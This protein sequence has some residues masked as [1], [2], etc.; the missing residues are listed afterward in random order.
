MSSEWSST[1]GYGFKLDVSGTLSALPE[2]DQRLDDIDNVVDT[3]FPRLVLGYAGS[4][5][6]SNGWEQWIFIKDSYAK[7]RDWSQPVDIDKMAASL[8]P[9]NMEELFR[10]VADTGTAIGEPQWRFMIDVG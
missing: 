1:I 5:F 10:F 8:T 2:Y 7:A 9:E 4:A 3:E 6:T